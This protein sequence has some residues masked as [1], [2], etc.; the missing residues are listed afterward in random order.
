MGNVKME[1]MDTKYNNKAA[2]THVSTSL[3]YILVGHVSCGAV[4]TKY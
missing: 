1:L 3:K 2:G 4:P